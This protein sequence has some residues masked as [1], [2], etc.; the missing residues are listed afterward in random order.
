MDNQIFSPRVYS[1]QAFCAAYS[2]SNSLAYEA[3]NA[4]L[5]RVKY[6]GTKPL[7]TQESADAFISSLP[8][9]PTPKAERK[10]A[11]SYKELFDAV[12]LHNK[13]GTTNINDLKGQDAK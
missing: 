12:K 2:I 13:D 3:V 8:D 5:L 4:G 10:A 11:W 6:A 7:I 1:M 9:E